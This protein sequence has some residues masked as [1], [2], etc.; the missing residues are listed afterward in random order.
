MTLF[1]GWWCGWMSAIV[2]ILL[3]EEHVPCGNRH[4]WLLFDEPY[5]RRG[6]CPPGWPITPGLK[7]LGKLA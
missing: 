5:L 7:E 3:L 4:Y 1:F 6:V 2:L